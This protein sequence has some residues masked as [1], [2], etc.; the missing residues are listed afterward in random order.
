[1]KLARPI[2]APA[3]LAAL[4]G[5]ATIRQLTA[6][7]RVDFS[8]AGVEDGRLAG[9]ELRRIAAYDDLGPL[10]VGRIAL[11]VTRRDVPL[12]FRVMVRADNPA[13]NGTA[14]T[15]V[16]LAWT[17]LLDDR[18]TIH[19]VLDTAV[20]IPPGETATIP[21]PMRVNLREFFDGPARSLVD[22]AASVAGLGSRPTRIAVRAVPTI[23]TP[24]GPITYP[25]PITIVSRTVGGSP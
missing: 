11:A 15:V 12:D 10:D 2:L 1:M 13:D 6:L 5:C 21:L 20:T 14:A 22:L 19:G 23:D 25:S 24:L 3:A 16:K 4:A 8:I 7:R 18:E 9:V 17:L